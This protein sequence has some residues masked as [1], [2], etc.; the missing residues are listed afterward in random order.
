MR[1]L[2]DPGRFSITYGQ[3]DI[4]GLYRLDL[5]RSLEGSDVPPGDAAKSNSV[6]YFSVNISTDESD[7]RGIADSELGTHFE[8]QPEQFL[9]YSEKV[10][11]RRQEQKQLLGREFWKHCLAAVIALLLLETALAQF[12]GR[13]AG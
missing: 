4:P 9:D 5:N 11:S 10:E 1:E 2:D 13:R 3:T 6:E 7:L 8:V 12:F